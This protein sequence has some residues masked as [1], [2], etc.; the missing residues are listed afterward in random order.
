LAALGNEQIASE[1]S[2]LRESQRGREGEREE[3]D[4]EKKQE[5]VLER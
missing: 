4:N 3:K 5:G 2:T 1:R